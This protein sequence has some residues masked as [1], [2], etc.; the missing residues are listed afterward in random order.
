[1]NDGDRSFVIRLAA[2]VLA[3]VVL[4]M[5]VVMLAGLFHPAVDNKEIFSILGPA[6]LTIVGV[7]VGLLGGMRPA[8]KE[9]GD[10]DEP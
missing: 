6:F 1:L 7:F 10:A 5:V 4:G 9:K 2:V 8:Q 3:G